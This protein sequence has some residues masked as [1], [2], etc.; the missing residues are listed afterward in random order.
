MGVT[1]IDLVDKDIFHAENVHRHFIGYDALR[2][3]GTH[4]KADLLKD[5]LTDKYPYVDIDSMNYRDQSVEK[6]VLAHPERLSHYDLIISALGEPTINLSINQLLIEK[7]IHTPFIVC[8]NEPYGIGGH[9]I[10]TNLSHESCLRC[11]YSD[12]VEGSLQ[13]FLGSLVAPG[14]NFKKSLSGCAGTFVPFSTL[15]SQQT[16]IHASHKAM[17]VL[18]GRLSQ[19]DL[20]TWRG[21][22]SLLISSGFKVSEYFSSPSPAIKFTNARCPVCQGRNS[23]A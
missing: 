22:P 7:C 5:I 15:D 23:I 8:F 9:V 12:L 14:Q 11:Y 3:T 2:R 6:V 20:F 21:D 10:T 1:Q 18:T 4:F 16:A 17:E 19:N 13:S